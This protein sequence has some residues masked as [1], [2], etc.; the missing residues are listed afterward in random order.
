MVE[1]P[2]LYWEKQG[3]KYQVTF[4]RVFLHIDEVT[5]AAAAAAI[6][7]VAFEL[8]TLWDYVPRFVR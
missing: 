8:Q 5:Q 1:T 3:R 4:Q 7:V 6:Y 2:T